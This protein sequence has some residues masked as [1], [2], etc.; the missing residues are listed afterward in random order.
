[1]SIPGI[2]EDEIA[3][4]LLHNPA[5]F[6]RHAELLAQVQLAHPHGQ[7]AV[8]LQERQM[9]MLRDKVRGLELRLAELL[10]HAQENAAIA[11]RLQR[12]L[13]G[14]LLAPQ[15]QGL[16]ERLLAG[17]RETFLVPQSA[18]RLWDPVAAEAGA[19]W[20]RPVAPTLRSLVRGLSLPRCGPADP[21]L[22]DGLF[23]SLP[24]S[25]AMLPL[26]AEGAGEAFGVLLLGSPDPSRYQDGMGVEFLM[27]IAELSSAALRRLQAG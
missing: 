17:L 14:L 15:P 21:V 16:P 1:M 11:E 10:R 26:R 5:F 12:W 24:A 4:Y 19:D 23:D 6:E 27:R 25:V 18:L 9:A 2:T 3:A 13:R 20:A 7:R 8:S 22:H